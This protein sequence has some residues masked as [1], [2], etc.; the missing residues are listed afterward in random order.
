MRRPQARQKA[1]AN[2]IDASSYIKTTTACYQPNKSEIA[3]FAHFE[4]PSRSSPR[5][6]WGDGRQRAATASGDGEVKEDGGRT[7]WRRVALFNDRVTL[8]RRRSILLNP[9]SK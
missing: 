6:R 3:A 2:G 8:E 1:A 5:G 4:P 9:Q 7:L